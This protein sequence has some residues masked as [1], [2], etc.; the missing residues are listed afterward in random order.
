M[1]ITTKIPASLARFVASEALKSTLLLKR[2][3][4]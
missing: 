2:L 3:D 1:P 4:Q